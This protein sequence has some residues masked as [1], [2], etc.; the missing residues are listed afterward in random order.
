M[1]QVSLRYF[2]F[3]NLHVDKA[4]SLK[5]E[6]VGMHQLLPFANWWE[7]AGCDLIGAQFSRK[8]ITFLE[9]KPA[10]PDKYIKVAKVSCRYYNLP[11]MIYWFPIKWMFHYV[12]TVQCEG[13]KYTHVSFWFKIADVSLTF[14]LFTVTFLLFWTN[15]SNLRHKLRA[16]T[17]CLYSAVSLFDFIRRWKETK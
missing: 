13:R 14:P 5:R 10:H 1:L 4:E 8:N 2:Y 17:L 6:H 7:L 9:Q 11:T 3:L 15:S 16:T 12:Y